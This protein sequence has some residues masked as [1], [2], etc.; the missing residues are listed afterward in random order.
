M[1]DKAVEVT[2][3]KP[4]K[5][6]H[7]Y[8][9][10]SFL[11]NMSSYVCTDCTRSYPGR[12]DD[13]YLPCPRSCPDCHG[14]GGCVTVGEARAYNHADHVRYNV[15]AS[16][17]SCHGGSFVV[18]QQTTWDAAIALIAG[19]FRRERDESSTVRVDDTTYEN[20][21]WVHTPRRPYQSTQF[22][23]TFT[24]GSLTMTIVPTP[25]AVPD[26][27]DELDAFEFAFDEYRWYI[28]NEHR[29]LWDR[30]EDE[31]WYEEDY[32]Y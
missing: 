26:R 31:D 13:E 29:D 23:L 6:R 10:P 7:S 25:P 28:G 17:S 1:A 8:S 19:I 14:A 11:S 22:T 30:E 16:F 5:Q 9:T 24:G 32:D 2:S 12:D 4:A 3:R 27:D 18:A 15:I 20:D 21:A